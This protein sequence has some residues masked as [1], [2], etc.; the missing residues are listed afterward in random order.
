MESKATMTGSS[1]DMNSSWKEA[2]DVFSPMLSKAQEA[3]QFIHDVQHSFLTSILGKAAQGLTLLDELTSFIFSALV[4][5]PLVTLQNYASQFYLSAQDTLSSMDSALLKDPTIGPILSSLQTKVQDLSVLLGQQDAVTL[6]PTLGIFVSA[7]VTYSIVST[8]LSLGNG[9]P[10]SRPYPLGR[11]DP[12]SARNYFDQRPLQSLQRGLEIAS[13]SAGFALKLLQDKIQNQ[14]E[15]N[16]DQRALELA[17]LLTILGPTFSKS[18]P[19]SFRIFV[20]IAL[21]VFF[22]CLLVRD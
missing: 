14:L 1:P 19:F 13:L 17:E 12:V 6:P 11:Y 18:S 7:M 4:L 21:D 5:L 10:P 20:L 22:V 3:G 9:P 8:I 2:W 16:Q 15:Q